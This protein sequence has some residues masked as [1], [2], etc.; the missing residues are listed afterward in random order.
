MI[1]CIAIDDEPLAL[2]I[3]SAFCADINF[4]QL[5]KTFTKTS[6]ALKYCLGTPGKGS[7]S[8]ACSK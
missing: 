2:E 6:D 3:V 7:I 5:Q 1:Q 4:I 8:K